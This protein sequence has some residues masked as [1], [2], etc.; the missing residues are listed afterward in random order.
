MSSK[1]FRKLSVWA[2]ILA[3]IIFVSVFLLKG[4]LRNGYDPISMYISEL[5]L[6]DRG[7][8]QIANFML[9]GFLLFLFTIG[10]S[11]EFQTGKASQ[12]GIIGFYIISGLFFISGL[13]IMD[14]AGTPVDQISVSGLIHEISGG[15]LFL[16]MP[17]IIFVFLRRFISDDQ[18][19]SLR[20]WT[21]IL[22]IVEALGVFVFIYASK[23]PAGQSA[24]GQFLGLFQRIAVIPFM[25]WV[26]IFGIEMLRKQTEASFQ[27]AS[28]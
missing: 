13:F 22:G 20:W 15:I 18:W 5:S 23:I 7:W 14:P 1:Q 3:P 17:I 27:G 10:L 28:D 25:V 4:A 16:L 12:W 6:G 24:L 11:K 19:K 9:L 2:G 26:T 21:L 8:I